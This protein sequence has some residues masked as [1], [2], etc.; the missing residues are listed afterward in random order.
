MSILLG[1]K[2]ASKL[3]RGRA[4]GTS[5]ERFRAPADGVANCRSFGLPFVIPPLKRTRFEDNLEGFFTYKEG[6]GV[7]LFSFTL[8]KKKIVGR[9]RNW[10]SGSSVSATVALWQ[11]PREIAAAC[12]KK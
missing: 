6:L 2:K 4:G 8:R 9:T 11:L 7:S 3:P 1:E 10:S 12:K 5:K